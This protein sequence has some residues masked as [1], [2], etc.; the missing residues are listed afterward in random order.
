MKRALAL[1]VGATMGAHVGPALS[2]VDVLRRRL[3]PGLAGRGSPPH[4]ALT[5]DDGPQPDSTPAFLDVLGQLG[6]RATFFMLG[7]M[8]RR[9]PVLA[10][11][12]AAAG[13]EI[14]VHG[15]AHRSE[16]LRPP[17][18]V[19]DDLARAVDTI[20]SV[21]GTMPLWFRP[22]YGTLTTAGLLAARR[23]RVRP[24]LW[25]TWG[26]DWRAEATPAT[27]VADVAR[28]LGPGAT[29]LLHDSDCTSATGAWHSALGALPVLS[30]LFA[31]RGLAVGPLAEH[32]LSRPGHGP[33]ASDDVTTL[34]AGREGAPH[35]GSRRA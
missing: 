30:E 12:V 26:R 10:A 29:V 19:V 18:Q 25:T 22:P 21:T 17:W 14:A 16:A 5:F 35:V 23:H 28:H 2:N 6:W 20:A 27:V 24:V 34:P 1:A 33:H 15:D 9:A 31:A 8:V 11:E 4:V 13:H 3:L 32:G 7:D